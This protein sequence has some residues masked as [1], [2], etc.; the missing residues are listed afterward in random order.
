[1]TRADDDEALQPLWPRLE[2]PSPWWRKW[3]ALAVF[4]ASVAVVPTIAWL[5]R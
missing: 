1:M 5:L 2:P 4:A 3:L